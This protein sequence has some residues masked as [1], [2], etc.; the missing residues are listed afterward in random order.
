METRTITPLSRPVVGT[1]R[2]P[3]SKSVTNRALVLAALADGETTLTNAL[4]ADDTRR[5]MDCL[6]S[7]GFP[8][9]ADKEARTITVRGMGGA[10]LARSAELF[11]GNSGTTARFVTPLVALAP[12]ATVTLDGVPRFRQ[13]P[14]G[15]LVDA[16]RE[17][18][19]VIETANGNAPLTI[20]TNGLRGE[21]L[22]C[23]V[24]ADRSSQFLSG[25]LMTLPCAECEETF[26]GIT[27]EVQS[28]P[29][30]T[31][32]VKMLYDFGAWLEVVED[33]KVF[34][35][36]GRQRYRA[37]P[38]YA[39]EPDASAASYFF[40]AAALTGGRVRVEGLGKGLLQ[41]DWAFADVLGKM[42]CVLRRGDGFIEVAAPTNSTLCGITVDMNAISD[43]VMTLA[44]IAPFADGPTV[45]ENVAHIREKETDRLS[46][47]AMEL[48][49]LG[50]RVEERP[51]GLTIYPADKITPAVVQTYDDHRMAMAF[52]LVGL[53]AEGVTIA[54]PN[55]VTKTFPGY[56]D[57]LARLTTESTT[58]T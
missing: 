39:V 37:K 12:N 58:T 36:S 27:G 28:E 54:D 49:R 18:G 26:V 53:R 51:D 29:Y 21:T 20:R 14:M 52:A 42:G 32:T 33:G 25:L 50:V 15:D 4:F 56:W 8:I 13:R 23:H 38:A 44:A 7:L 10:V 30:I 19:V 55:C 47:M 16:L 3:G 46:A 1:A 2:L 17:L 34:V 11:V 48:T 5:M 41:G 43:T 31:M 45:I 40:A 22:A 24:R 35:V 6:I 57:E 9:F